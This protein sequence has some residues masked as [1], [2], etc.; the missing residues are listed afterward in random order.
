MTTK[1][2]IIWDLD[3]C[4][5]KDNWR[6]DKIDW[7]TKCMDARYAEYHSHCGKDIP[8]NVYLFKESLKNAYPIFIT[9]RP[10][11]FRKETSVWINVHLVH[12]DQYWLFMREPGD[13][14][15]SVEV[16]QEVLI[17]LE[18]NRTLKYTDIIAAYDDRADIVEMYQWFRIDAHILQITEQ[19]D[20]DS[21][22]IPN[23]KTKEKKRAPDIL[24]DAAET[25]RQRNAM[26]G[27]NYLDFGKLCT[28]L[29]PKGLTITTEAQHNRYIMF[30]QCLLKLTRYAAMLGKGGHQDSA[31]DL[32]VYSAMLEEITDVS[33]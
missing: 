5:S 19:P 16:K 8:C 21:S 29:F 30:V 12:D 27:D 28:V 18:K 31:H 1:K 22:V 3:N 9:S 7:S 25:F 4:L 26:Y 10:E 2:Y 11:K 33:L 32:A 20:N 23:S 14:R 6:L 17:N 24:A 15:K 13:Y